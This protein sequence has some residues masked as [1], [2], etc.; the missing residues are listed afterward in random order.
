MVSI[1]CGLLFTS[2]VWMM[3]SIPIFILQQ[4]DSQAGKFSGTSEFRLRVEVCES[5][6]RVYGE[7]MS[8]HDT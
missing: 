6:L 5:I 8:W 7:L 3:V 4:P 2:G 1:E